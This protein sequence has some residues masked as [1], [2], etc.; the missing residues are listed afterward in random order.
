MFDS[1][2]TCPTM[3]T[4]IRRNYPVVCTPL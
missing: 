1:E 2:T 3:Q 4:A